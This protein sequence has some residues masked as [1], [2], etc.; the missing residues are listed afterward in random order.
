[1]KININ[2]EID[3]ENSQD[4]STIEELIEALKQL[5]LQSESE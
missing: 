3:T 2:I 5:K 1:M 4:I